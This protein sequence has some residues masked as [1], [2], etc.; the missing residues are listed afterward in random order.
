MSSNVLPADA[1]FQPAASDKQSTRARLWFPTLMVVLFWSAFGAVSIMDVPMFTRFM[2]RAGGGA[3]L[4]L[5]TLIWWIFVYRRLGWRARLLCVAAAVAAGAITALICGQNIKLFPLLL[6]AVPIV[7]TSWVAWQHLAWYSTDRMRLIGTL[8]AVSLPWIPFLFLRMNGLTGGVEIQL[9]WRWNPSAED[10]FLAEHPK[11]VVAPQ[12][13]IVASAAMKIEQPDDWSG[14]RGP[15]RDGVVHGS[16]IDTDWSSNPPKALWRQRAG[17]SWS[18]M[19]VI[20]ERL[21]TQEQRGESEVVVCLDAATGKEVWVHAD[22]V[23]HWDGESGVGPR[24]TPAY[25]NGRVVAL[26]GEG[27]LNCLDI[28]NGAVLWTRDIKADSGGTTP[29]W[30]FSSSPL[31]SGGLVVIFAGAE[32]KGDKKNLLAYNL[33]TGAPVWSVPDGQMAYASPQPAVLLGVPQVLTFT[34]RG[35]MSVDPA[36]GKTLWEFPNENKKAWRAI[37]PH[38]LNGNSVMLSSESDFGTLLLDVTHTDG[39][40]TAKERWHTRN[41]KA[42][43]NDY[44]ILDGY[45][46]GFDGGIFCCID[47][48]TGDRKWKGGHYDH[49]QMLLLADQALILVLTEHGEVVLLSATPEKFNELGKFEAIEGKTWNHPAFARGRLYVRNAVEMACYAL[50]E[51]K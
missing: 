7:L 27:T 47:A 13:K 39:T 2:T 40:W 37:Q 12:P 23:R 16:H 29:I 18:S 46:Y 25:A 24:A 32:G 9:E 43:Y 34:D 6:M 11:R 48:N 5:S 51:K 20:G 41:L 14:F 15:N 42:S 44:A 30:G 17:P 8:L 49:G 28:A 21:I 45:V 4:L 36:N 26:G 19:V 3:L 35:L 50:P 10:L 33:E 22:P 31:I 38:P 1:A